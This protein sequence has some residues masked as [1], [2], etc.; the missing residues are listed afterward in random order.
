MSGPAYLMDEGCTKQRLRR[1][2]NFD[3]HIEASTQHFRVSGRTSQRIRRF[4]LYGFLVREFEP[5]VIRVQISFHCEY[6]RSSGFS[7]Q[8]SLGG[9][10][11]R[12]VVDAIRC[13]GQLPRSD[14][15]SSRDDDRFPLLEPLLRR[16]VAID[17]LVS[18]TEDPVVGAAVTS[19]SDL[20]RCSCLV[21]YRP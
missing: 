18:R 7:C 3:R 9:N 19:P 6:R 16:L 12:A 17:C 11:R 13:P 15:L 21:W 14:G 8:T 1:G 20:Q 2:A 5:L 4:Y 10:Q